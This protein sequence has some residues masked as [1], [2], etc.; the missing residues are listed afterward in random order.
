MISLKWL[1]A[2][3]HLPPPHADAVNSA[4]AF[5]AARAR[6]AIGIKGAGVAIGF[7]EVEG[8]TH[9]FSVVTVAGGDAARAYSVERA[10]GLEAFAAGST[11]CIKGASKGKGRR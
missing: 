5:H 8:S 1:L 2:A 7:V 9:R 6:A 4:T 11:V 3:P 10:G